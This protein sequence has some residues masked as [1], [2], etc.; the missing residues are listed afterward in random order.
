MPI[1]SA[2]AANAGMVAFETRSEEA[3]VAIDECV[4][5]GPRRAEI[6]QDHLAGLERVLVVGEV[7]VGLHQAE[8]EELA[9]Q[10]AD[11]QR[12]RPVSLGLWRGGQSLDR[13]A[14]DEAHGQHVRRGEVRVKVG[15]AE[16]GP[17]GEQ[18]AELR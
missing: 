8:L 2:A 17:V 5:K 7:R 4:G 10:E 16:F 15:H 12:H 11:Q 3:T 1:S 18:R 9:E 14:L 6:E 13:K